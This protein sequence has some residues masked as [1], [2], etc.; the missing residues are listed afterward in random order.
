MHA[1]VQTE[2]TSKSLPS[3]RRSPLFMCLCFFPVWYTNTYRY[4]Y[5]SF[6]FYRVPYCT[7]Y[8]CFLCLIYFRD[9]SLSVHRELYHTLN[10]YT[11]IFLLLFSILSFIVWVLLGLFSWF[12]VVVSFFFRYSFQMAKY[13]NHECPIRLDL[14]NACAEYQDTDI[15]IT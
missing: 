14:T 4:F 10:Y 8:T 7:Y 3:H 11:N 15:F 2:Q 9:F 5:L 6:F 1:Y 12:V 13:V